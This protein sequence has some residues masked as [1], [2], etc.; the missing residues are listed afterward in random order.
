L[1][2]STATVRPICRRRDGCR[3]LRDEAPHAHG[4]QQPARGRQLLRLQRSQR[5]R[6]VRDEFALRN[7]DDTRHREHEDQREREQCVDRARG[8]A[9]LRENRRNR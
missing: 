3:D 7:E 6:A 9:V 4:N 5:Q 1:P 8:D 2:A